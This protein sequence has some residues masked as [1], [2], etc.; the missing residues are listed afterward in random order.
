MS[1][2]TESGSND[3]R[4]GSRAKE[5]EEALSGGAEW[6]RGYSIE[7]HAYND[8]LDCE[9]CGR[10]IVEVGGRLVVYKFT[11]KEGLPMPTYARL[12]HGCSPQEK[13]ADWLSEGDWPQVD[14]TAIEAP[15]EDLSANVSMS[16]AGDAEVNWEEVDSV[17]AQ[18]EDHDA[19][20]DLCKRS[21]WECDGWLRSFKGT[22]RGKAAGMVYF[23]VCFSCAPTNLE[24]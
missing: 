2:K 5:I 21:I 8:H 24:D 11:P 6:E 4:D 9:L 20:C 17:Q 14:W 19:E 1:R 23:R 7:V 12:C 15:P 13:K 3:E 22:L 10:N 16:N 18:G